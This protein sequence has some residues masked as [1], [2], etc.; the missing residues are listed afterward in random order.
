MAGA[1]L[2]TGALYRYFKDKDDLF[3]VLA[4]PVCKAF[5]EQYVLVGDRLS[6]KA[7]SI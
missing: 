4:L 2:T 1:S 6:G 5:L 3:S 7:R